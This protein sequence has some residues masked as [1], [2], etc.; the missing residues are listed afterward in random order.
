MPRAADAVPASASRGT[1]RT[2]RLPG[3]PG[4]DTCIRRIIPR[5]RDWHLFIDQNRIQGSRARDT[6]A[7]GAEAPATV[8]VQD[9]QCLR[10][11]AHGLVLVGSVLD[12]DHAAHEIDR[13]DRDRPP[14][15]A[16]PGH[17]VVVE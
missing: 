7:A 6:Q 9:A 8:S 15:L 12:D 3:G 10:V 16:V 2:M 13:D 17:L 5:W 1:S 11:E 14:R 4:R